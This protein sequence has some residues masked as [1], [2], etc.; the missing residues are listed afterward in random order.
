MGKVSNWR[1]LFLCT[2][3]TCR[4]PMAEGIARKIFAERNIPAE[5]ASCGTLEL[6]GMSPSDHAVRVCAER[7]IDISSHRSQM[8]T[9]ELADW[10]NIIFVMEK[11]HKLWVLENLGHS[12]YGKTLLISQLIQGESAYEIPDPIGMPIQFY[13][14]V[15]DMLWNA[16]ESIAEKISAT[17]DQ[18][19]GQPS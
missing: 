9:A 19:W 14:Q 1:I 2:G 10:A 15:F 4:S 17:E 3:N 12:V 11:W 6:G 18:V 8:L 16:I 7:G 5:F 13:E